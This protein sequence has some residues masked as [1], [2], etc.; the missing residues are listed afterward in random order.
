MQQLAQAIRTIIHDELPEVQESFYGGRH[1][2]AMYRTTAELCWLQPLKARCNLYFLRGTELTDEGGL[3][4]GTSKR[5]RH[6]KIKSLDQL[7]RLP[8]REWLQESIELNAASLDAGIT[9]DEV[10]GKLR[11]IC[12]GLPRTKETATWGKPHFRVG[13]KI[14]CGCGEQNGRPSLGLKMPPDEARILMRVPGVSK[15]PYSRPNDGWV[16]I[17]PCTFDDWDEIERLIVGS[18]RL[19]APKRTSALLDRR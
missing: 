17:D 8:V 1:A 14:F 6:V 12:L 7:E 3:L 19:V 16:A 11:T 4:E 18:Y 9:F 2:M 10:L 15:A 5:H 13:E